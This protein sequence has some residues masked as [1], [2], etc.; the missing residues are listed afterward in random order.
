[1][2]LKMPK[3]QGESLSTEDAKVEAQPAMKGEL[4][5]LL[6]AMD[7]AKGVQR[8]HKGSNIPVIDRLPTGIFE[9]DFNSG[10]GLPKN[11]LSMVYG[12]EGAGKSNLLYRV[13]A[14]VQR[15]TEEPN[16]VVW[17][18]LEHQFD[19]V[20]VAQFGVDLDKLVV[21]K[22]GYG[23]EAVDMVDAIVRADDVAYIVVDSIAVLTATRELEKSTESADVGTSA[24]LVKRLCNRLAFGLSHEQS[25]GHTPSVSFVNQRRFKPGV[26]HGDPETIPGGE[27]MKFLSSMTV[28]L[29][30]TAKVDKT[31]HPDMPVWR[32]THVRMKKTRC[33][34]RA[35]E[36]DYDMALINHNGMSPGETDSFKLVWAL[37]KEQGKAEK[38]PG[39]WKCLGKTY[40]T[41]APIQDT[42]YGETAFQMLLQK[43][44]LDGVK[45]Q[46]MF[47]VSA[48]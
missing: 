43:S 34:V 22:P 23:E 18:D 9:F 39:G 48:E 19:P 37:L 35:V 6:A 1:M 30:S 38:I 15:L 20:W 24:M 45:D 40:P 8:W 47:A 21:L 42:Y 33:L 14:N 41:I 28:R 12:P 5:T 29:N 31:L 36:F 17:V 4:A 46:K 16:I 25:R 32:E 27:T 11:R 13:A 44:V 10:G 3:S 2:A 26:L 7:K